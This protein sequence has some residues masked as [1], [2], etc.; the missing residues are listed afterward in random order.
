MQAI[1]WIINITHVMKCE[2]IYQNVMFMDGVQFR[3]TFS[4]H[5]DWF[6]MQLIVVSL[7]V[8]LSVLFCLLH[9]LNS[10]VAEFVRPYGCAML[11]LSFFL[12]MPKVYNMKSWYAIIG[13]AFSFGAPAMRRAVERTLNREE[14]NTN[15][16]AHLATNW[17]WHTLAS[18]TCAL[19]HTT[20]RSNV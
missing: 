19:I 4:Y 11:S 1:W 9:Y 2:K 18:F 7:I 13:V 20:T 12:I 14:Q 3:V 16:N 8:K 5:F 17:V 6:S 15:D 10:N